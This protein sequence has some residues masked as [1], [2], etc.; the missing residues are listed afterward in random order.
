[1][2]SRRI[3][4]NHSLVGVSSVLLPS[5]LKTS[6]GKQLLVA[7]K[8]KQDY[9]T[10]EDFWNLI[11]QAYHVSHPIVNLNNAGVSPHTKAVQETIERHQRVSNE[12]PSYYMWRTLGKNREPIRAALAGLAGCSAEE[13]AINRNATEALETIIFGLSLR[14]GD[15]VVL[16]KY[17]YPAMLNAW[18][19]REKRDGIILKW[20]DLILPSED[21]AALTKAYTDQFTTKT[22]VVHLT[23]MLNWS[24]QILPVR[25]IALVAKQ[26]GIEV[27]VDGAQSFAQLDFTIPD[28]E[29]DYFGTSLH[30]WLGGPFGTGMLYVKKEKIKNLYP[31]FAPPEGQETD[32]RK[33]EHLGTHDL[34]IE[35]A[36]GTAIDFHEMIG[37]SRKE[38]RLRYLS[39]YWM[40]RVKDLPNV[41]IHTP[42]NSPF[43]GALGLFNIRGITPRK[44]HGK[45]LQTNQIHLTT[46]RIDPLVGCRVSPNVY[47]LTKDLDRLVEA[48]HELAK[49]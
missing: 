21:T 41:D 20:V 42:I 25:D 4:L 30:K 15:E 14:A 17:D 2:T 1:M 28:L 47:T 45:M 49:V 34:A 39:T 44:I 31:L 23:H 5:F 26:Q 19:Q 27:I 9:T 29:C 33:F 35:N 48:I 40:E 12:M 10:D 11:R 22:K 6:T 38:K 37:I 43:S 46:S 3:F 8:S 7:S 36:I 32:I 24:G 18:K 16:G 13:I